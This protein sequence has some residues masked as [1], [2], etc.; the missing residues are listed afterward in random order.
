[1]MKLA[2][3]GFIAWATL[4]GA[5]LGDVSVTHWRLHKCIDGLNDIINN[6]EYGP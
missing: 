2:I 1:M 5:L 6:S 3:I 4:T